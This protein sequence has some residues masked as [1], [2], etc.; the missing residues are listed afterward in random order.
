MVKMIKIEDSTHLKLSHQGSVGDSYDDVINRL[1]DTFNKS[2]ILILYRLT[3]KKPPRELYLMNS[4]FWT[5]ENYDIFLKLAND[6][7]KNWIRSLLRSIAKN[8]EL[9]N[10]IEQ[11][12]KEIK[13]S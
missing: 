5:N 7:D 8:D 10:I 2:E 13:N 1:I 12:R 3:N 9:F 11:Y 4:F 6:L